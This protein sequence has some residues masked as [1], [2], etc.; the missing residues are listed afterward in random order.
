MGDR[1]KLEKTWMSL[2]TRF[3]LALGLRGAGKE[4]I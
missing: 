2:W 3:L 1:S 4:E